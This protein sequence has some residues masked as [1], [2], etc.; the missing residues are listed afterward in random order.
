MADADPKEGFLEEAY[1]VFDNGVAAGRGYRRTRQVE[2][3]G[4]EAR[5]R[6][7]SRSRPTPRPLAVPL[8]QEEANNSS[9]RAS[10]FAFLPGG[11]ERFGFYA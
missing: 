3:E 9:A 10:V 2:E 4:G 1:H 5:S 6:S 8:G 11:E 7:R